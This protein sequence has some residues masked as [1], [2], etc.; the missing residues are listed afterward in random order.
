MASVENCARHLS[1]STELV[2]LISAFLDGSDISKLYLCGEKRMC[3]L[4]ETANITFDLNYGPARPSL[5]PSIIS[6]FRG[7]HR[8]KLSITPTR[9]QNFRPSI[10]FGASIQSIP[11]TVRHIDFD[12]DNDIS[13]FLEYANNSTKL[14]LIEI[15]KLFPELQTLS[16]RSVPHPAWSGLLLHPADLPCNL[17]TWN[18]HQYYLPITPSEVSKLPKSLTSLSITIL[19]DEA[20]EIGTNFRLPPSLVKLVITNQCD[21]EWAFLSHLAPTITD[22]TL[23]CDAS[24]QLIPVA[25]LASVPRS[26]H[27]LAISNFQF[28]AVVNCW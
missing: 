28:P 24:T 9:W 12:F 6:R 16:C 4:I 20:H 10:L 8:L 11:S 14:K 27:S 18:F 23:K 25:G 1:A 17:Q 2:M 13:L 15:S 3:N 26:M 22:L 7:M 19:K 5:W 21:P